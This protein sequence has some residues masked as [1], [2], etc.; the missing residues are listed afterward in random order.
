M[1]GISAKKCVH[2]RNVGRQVPRSAK[3]LFFR[4][5]SAKYLF[6]DKYKVFC[7]DP[8]KGVSNS[9]DIG[10]NSKIITTILKYTLK[11]LRYLKYIFFLIRANAIVGDGAARRM[12]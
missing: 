2:I 1:G 11:Y 5:G 3:Y 7:A 12:T 9:D 8:Q 4:I 6:A 10:I